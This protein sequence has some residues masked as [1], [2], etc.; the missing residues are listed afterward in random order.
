MAQPQMAA[1]GTWKSPITAAEAFA[2]SVGIGGIRLSLAGP[3]GMQRTYI[4][5]SSLSTLRK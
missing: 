3:V 5:L 1:Y 2:N 4:H